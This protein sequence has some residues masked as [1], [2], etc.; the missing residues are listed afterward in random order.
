MFRSHGYARIKCLVFGAYD[1]KG[2]AISLGYNLHKDKRLNH[3]FDVVGGV[4]HY[5]CSKIL[6][7]FFK[8]K[9]SLITIFFNL[10]IF[11]NLWTPSHESG[12]ETFYFENRRV[13]EGARL[14][15]CIP[16]GIGGSNPLF[17]AIMNHLNFL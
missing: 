17:S 10:I 11:W 14:K 3:R 7:A 4:H 2:G 12:P 8:E 5:E 15:A 6:S 9:E 16:Q 13:V 1:P